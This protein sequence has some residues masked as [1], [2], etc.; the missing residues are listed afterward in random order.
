[1]ENDKLVKKKKDFVIHLVE[2]RD[3]I[4]DAIKKW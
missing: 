2:T 1:M 3:T 4:L